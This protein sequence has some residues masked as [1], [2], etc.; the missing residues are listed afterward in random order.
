MD[1]QLE[2]TSGSIPYVNAYAHTFARP[3]ILASKVRVFGD[4]KLGLTVRRL[5][6]CLLSGSL[7]R[8]EIAP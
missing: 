4:L 2:A 5:F 3:Q 8:I 7:I 6:E 1:S